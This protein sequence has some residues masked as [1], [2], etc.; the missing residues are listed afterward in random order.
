MMAQGEGLLHTSRQL[1]EGTIFRRPTLT[2]VA[3]GMRRRI[4]DILPRG[5]VVARTIHQL[6]GNLSPRKKTLAFVVAG[7][8]GLALVLLLLLEI[9]VRIE[10]SK[11]A[12]D[13][14]IDGTPAPSANPEK[15]KFGDASFVQS[16]I[17]ALLQSV[18]QLD[19][20]GPTS[21]S[22]HSQTYGQI[23]R[24]PVPLPRPRAPVRVAR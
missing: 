9:S 18:S 23:S 21:S 5:E 13:T 3:A 16:T 17:S 19:A 7:V 1:L 24:E 11:E 15:M 4:D 12:S 8:V 2:F 10:L 22:D 6:L 14:A 20:T